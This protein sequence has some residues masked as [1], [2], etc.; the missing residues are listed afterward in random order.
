MGSSMDTDT[1]QK[2]FG[3]R[4]PTPFIHTDHSVV[5]DFARKAISSGRILE[6]MDTYDHLI[7]LLPEHSIALLTDLYDTL[8]KLHSKDRYEIYQ[9]RFYN[10]AINHG[11]KVLDV[12]SGNVPFLLATHLADLTLDED[13]HGRAGCAFKY[14]N[15]KTVYE[16]DI[17]NMPFSDKEFDF[18][19]CSHVLEHVKDPGKACREL[20]RVGSRGYIETPTWAKDL[21]FNTIRKSNH[22]WRISLEGNV[23]EFRRY[24]DKEQRG[25][26][27]D[28]F[29]DMNADPKSDREKAVYALAHLRADLLNVMHLWENEILFRVFENGKLV[30]TNTRSNT[31]FVPRTRS[32]TASRDHYNNC[33]FDWQKNI[34][35]FGG[36]ANL[37]KFKEFIKPSDAVID[38]GCGGG[39][40]LHNIECSLKTGIELNPAARQRASE[41]GIMAYSE[42]KELDDDCADVIISNHALEHVLSPYDELK[43]L[44][45]KI[46]PGG[47]VVFVVPHEDTRV[48]FNPQDINQHLYTW[49]QQTLGNLFKAAGF[50][51][52]SVE[53][54]QH[55]W[56]DNYAEVYE[57]LGE[58]E[59]HRIC[60]E[61]AVKNN[62]YQIRVVAVKQASL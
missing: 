14:L 18:V 36:R 52:Q 59:F 38:F 27:S 55:Q 6:G 47:L 28:L 41:N 39:F 32:H 11:T 61:N 2:Q 46:K 44:Y 43:Q 26:G 56:P 50:D 22:I 9:A 24:T 10:F 17:E 57:Q 54:I 13:K 5:V 33:Y 53:A 37:F 23:L 16:C 21:F 34:G 60:H 7:H 12:G 51:V 20:V 62:N 25:F 31:K 1:I 58:Q 4:I 45:K 40:L 42:V 48:G 49:N 35:D 29:L 30:D 15:G 8:S 3:P 19:Y